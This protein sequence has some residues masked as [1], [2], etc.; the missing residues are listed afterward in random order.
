MTVDI[1]KYSV[2]RA[3]IKSMYESRFKDDPN[4]AI[5]YLASMTMVPCIV[6]CFYLAEVDGFTPFW[7]EQIN[8]FIDFYGYTSIEN[9][10]ENCPI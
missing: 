7:I 6:V 2:N 1:E 8:E 10:P 9:K 4:R 5:G 3:Y